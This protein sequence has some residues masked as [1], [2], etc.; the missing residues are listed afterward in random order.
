VRLRWGIVAPLPCAG[1]AERAANARCALSVARR[2][3]A[4]VFISHRDLLEVNARALFELLARWRETALR[5][6]RGR[7]PRA[8][9]PSAAALQRAPRSSACVYF[10]AVQ[11]H[12]DW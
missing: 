11:N 10:N 9:G 2:Y 6:S 3:G 7:G 4:A 12:S 8:A 1:S 5:S